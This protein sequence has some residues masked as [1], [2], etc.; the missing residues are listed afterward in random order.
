MYFQHEEV[1]PHSSREFRNFLNY[2]FQGRW[3]GRAGL[4]NWPANFPELSPLN[5]CMGMDE[6]TGLECEGG[7]ARCIAWSHFRCSRPHHK[8]SAEAATSNSRSS[9]PS[10]SLC[11]GRRWLFRK[12]ALSTDKFKLNVI[13][14]SL[15][16]IYTLYISCI[17]LVYY[18]FRLL[19]IIVTFYSKFQAVITP[20]PSKFGHMFI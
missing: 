16:F 2:L 5:Y 6:I 9:Q 11:C 4:H 20:L 13:S 10:G 1:L 12:P 15:I 7:N 14:P 17:M 3:I 8:Q 19:L 18:F